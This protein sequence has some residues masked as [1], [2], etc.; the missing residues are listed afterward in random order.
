MGLVDSVSGLR[1]KGFEGTSSG[2]FSRDVCRGKDSHSYTQG[3]KLVP[4]DLYVCLYVSVCVCLY[5]SCVLYYDW[6]Q[7]FCLYLVI[8]NQLQMLWF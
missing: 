2:T 6:F 8:F 1:G 5:V 4:L 3:Q 7:C